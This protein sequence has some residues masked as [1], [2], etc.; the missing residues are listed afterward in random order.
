MVG[1]TVDTGAA[2]EIQFD[3]PG[4]YDPLVTTSNEHDQRSSLG[5]WSLLTCWGGIVSCVFGVG[6]MLGAGG[7]RRVFTHYVLVAVVS[8]AQ[9]TAFGLWMVRAD[10]AGGAGASPRVVRQ[11]GPPGQAARTARCGVGWH[12]GGLDRALASWVSL[13]RRWTRCARSV[14]GASGT[15]AARG[16]PRAPA[17]PL[18]PLRGLRGH[19]THA[20]EDP[21][22]ARREAWSA[23]TV[24]R[25]GLVV[26]VVAL[27][28]LLV[29]TSRLPAAGGG[30]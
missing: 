15:G 3:Q 11:S 29:G 6:L 27:T 14:D 7:V 17:G 30:G 8:S 9:L 20:E 10:L 1:W 23:T 24:P 18:V 28:V 2:R 25:R 4:R 22:I 19:P 13:R 21:D 5:E 26:V 12:L 16:V